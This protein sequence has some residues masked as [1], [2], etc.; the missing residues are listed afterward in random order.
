MEESTRHWFDKLETSFND[1]KDRYIEKS[2]EISTK[3]DAVL[4]HHADFDS[5]LDNLE[6][7][8]HTKEG[9][10]S[11]RDRSSEKRFKRWGIIIVAAEVVVAIIVA[12]GL[13]LLWG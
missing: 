6:K 8:K 10:D 12:V 7:W 13:K 2:S 9:Q 3:L 4:S 1:F 11:E 5:R